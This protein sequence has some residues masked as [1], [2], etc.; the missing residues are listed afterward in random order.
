MA[1]T[2]C[3]RSGNAASTAAVVVVTLVIEHLQGLEHV[4][5]LQD[6]LHHSTHRRTDI[7]IWN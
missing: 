3:F 6:Q 1:K 2:A 5:T 7:Y 4:E